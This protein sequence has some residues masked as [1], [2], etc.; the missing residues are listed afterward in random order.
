MPMSEDESVAI[1]KV[2]LGGAFPDAFATIGR[3]I[4][5][6]WDGN[7]LGQARGLIP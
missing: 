2:R 7:Q 3:D 6:V 4:R 5:E 1:V